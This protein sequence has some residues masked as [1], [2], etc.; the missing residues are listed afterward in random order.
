MSWFLAGVQDEAVPGERGEERVQGGPGAHEGIERCEEAELFGAFVDVVARDDG[1]F[2]RRISR[3]FG[4]F[5]RV[6]VVQ[7]D[8]EEFGE[9]AVVGVPAEDVEAGAEE[10]FE[11]PACVSGADV[12]VPCVG[13]TGCQSHSA[14]DRRGLDVRDVGDDGSAFAEHA[15][16][17]ANELCIVVKVFEHVDNDDDVEGFIF[18]GQRFSIDL[19]HVCRHDVT[20][21]RNGVGVEVGAVPRSA[22]NAQKVA[23]DAVVRAEVEAGDRGGVVE[24]SADGPPLGLFEHG[25]I[26]EAEVP[27]LGGRFHDG[28]V[29]RRVCVHDA[30]NHIGKMIVR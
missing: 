18:E 24:V 21:G 14:E 5:S 16:D 13:Q 29:R 28:P 7:G 12:S 26:E 17:F 27:V 19:M 30:S 25:L 8:V 1:A 23:D 9:R 4:R 20:D 10:V 22:A 11:L 3:R 15:V 6:D 2:G